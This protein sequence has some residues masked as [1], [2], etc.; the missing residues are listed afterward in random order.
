MQDKILS[1]YAKSNR[2]KNSQ[3]LLVENIL[4]ICDS[5]IKVKRREPF[6]IIEVIKHSQK[7]F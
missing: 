3:V 1:L 4:R 5:W 6:K 7:I 2:K